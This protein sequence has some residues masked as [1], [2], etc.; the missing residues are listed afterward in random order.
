MIWFH[1]SDGGGG[2]DTWHNDLHRNLSNIIEI[3]KQPLSSAEI[4]AQQVIASDIIGQLKIGADLIDDTGDA[5]W[6]QS[7][8]ELNKVLPDDQKIYIPPAPNI[9]QA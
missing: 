4:K 8:T 2:I 3:L 7:V 1:H 9:P 6:L 5:H